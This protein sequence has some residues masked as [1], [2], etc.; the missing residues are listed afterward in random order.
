ME[1]WAKIRR[2]L[3]SEGMAIKVIARQAGVARNAVRAA[4]AAET[5]PKYVGLWP[6]NHGP[7][8]T[9]GLAMQG[10]G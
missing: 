7:R 2:L 1:D 6:V 8:P 10:A 4:L 3:R 5:P 9:G